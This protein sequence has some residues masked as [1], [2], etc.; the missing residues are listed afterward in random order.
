[1]STQTEGAGAPAT[2]PAIAP[3]TLVVGLLI[4][5]CALLLLKWL[6]VVALVALGLAALVWW[7]RR[8]PTAPRRPSPRRA[9]AAGHDGSG[10][11]GP[12]EPPRVFPAGSG[13]DDCTWCGLP[14][15]HRDLKGRP[16]RPRHVHQLR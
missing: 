15:G 9:I 13:V 7:A 1:M 16:T 12:V 10:F 2:R 5:F 11:R 6:A 4:A 8:D 3:T 14:G